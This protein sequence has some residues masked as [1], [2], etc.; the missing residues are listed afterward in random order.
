MNYVFIKYFLFCHKNLQ[1]VYF[2]IKLSK[3]SSFFCI[4]KDNERIL[5]KKDQI[6]FSVA[7]CRSPFTQKRVYEKY[8]KPFYQ[9]MTGT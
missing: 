4:N 2:L 9:I 6:F 1:F 3:S 5:T 7:V 8:R